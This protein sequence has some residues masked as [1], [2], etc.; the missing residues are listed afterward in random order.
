MLKL[1]SNICFREFSLDKNSVLCKFT[2]NVNS[3]FCLKS[4][5]VYDTRDEYTL[6]SDVR[7]RRFAKGLSPGSWEGIIKQST[8]SPG[9]E[10]PEGWLHNLVTSRL[11]LC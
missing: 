9:I 2:V 8:A 7:V 4:S 10:I 11:E 1:S 6:G 5:Q 3:K